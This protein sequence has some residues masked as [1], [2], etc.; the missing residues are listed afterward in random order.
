VPIV[1]GQE[2]FAAVEER[3]TVRP[4]VVVTISSSPFD[5]MARTGIWAKCAHTLLKANPLYIL[6]IPPGEACLRGGDDILLGG[7]SKPHSFARCK[8]ST[9]STQDK[10]STG[11]S[12]PVMRG[13]PPPRLY[14]RT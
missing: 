3:V 7:K 9:S 13:L 1:G 6:L 5:V 10:S 2:S 8:G 14:I 4:S 12:F 11:K